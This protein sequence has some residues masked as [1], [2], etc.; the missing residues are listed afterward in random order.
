MPKINKLII[1]IIVI[2]IIIIIVI[3]I[4]III[5][6]VYSIILFFGLVL[7]RNQYMIQLFGFY[8]MQVLMIDVFEQ[9]LKF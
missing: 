7:Y 3:M 2:V 6:I 8:K 9:T 1:L 5:I 4:V